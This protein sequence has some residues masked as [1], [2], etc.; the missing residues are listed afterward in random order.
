MVRLYKGAW[1]YSY[2]YRA[3]YIGTFLNIYKGALDCCKVYKGFYIGTSLIFLNLGL[4]YIYFFIIL[5]FF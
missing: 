5:V 2:I 4:I 3:V 1:T